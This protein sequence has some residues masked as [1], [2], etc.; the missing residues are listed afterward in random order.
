MVVVI[1][2]SRIRD[3]NTEAF[4]LLAD[5]LYDIASAMPGFVSYKVFKNE[6]GERVSIHEWETADH[7]RAWREHPVHQAAQKMGREKFYESY[8]LQVCESPRE[9]RFP[10]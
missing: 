6:D 4:Q 10:V 7:L 1:F 9:S 8:I 5:Q 2:R 3:E